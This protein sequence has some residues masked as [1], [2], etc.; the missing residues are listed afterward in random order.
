MNVKLKERLELFSTNTQTMKKDFFWQDMLIKH[1]AALLYA[2]ENKNIDCDEI[3][4]CHELIKKNT[5]VFSTFRGN[6]AICI[7]SMLSLSENRDE[8]L[9]NTLTVYNS[10]KES[11]FK[12]SDYLAVA[13]YQIASDTD[14]LNYSKIIDRTK[15]FYDGM[16]ENHWFYTGKDD[17]IFAAMLGL[18]EINVNT[19]AARMEQ[20]HERLK[21]EFRFGN[22]IQ[23][24]TQVLILGGE[25]TETVNRLLR[26][27]ELFRDKKIRMDKEYTLSSLGVLS[28]LP[29]DVD[30]IADDVSKAYEFL[31]V[32]KGF[33]ALSVTNQELL[34]LSASVVASIYADDVKSGILTT[35]LSTSITNII[36]AQ[37][38]VLT[39]AVAT[40][41][42]ASASSSSSS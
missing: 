3:R 19:G 13:A 12:A 23:A 1:L 10:M 14:Q 24:L 11:K 28:L 20:L 5:G 9:S 27:R 32:Q 7:A 25:S 41:A 42:A 37:Q 22:S 21:S 29:T 8:Q 34:L 38:M 18:S 2:V 16:K 33:G 35:T 39:A 36:I 30:T 26:L 15:A 4:K 31:R 6:M 17:Y 40:S